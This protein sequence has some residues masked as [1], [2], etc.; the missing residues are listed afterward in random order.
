MLTITKFDRDV[1]REI[2]QEAVAELQALAAKLGL[3]VETAGGK[4]S[5]AE[6]TCH[7]KFTVN[8]AAAREA[9]ERKL[10]N[11]NCSFLELRPS[12]YGAQFTSRGVTYAAFGFTTSGKF[13]VKA[14][15]VATGKEMRF[16]EVVTQLIIAKRP[17]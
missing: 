16:S 14:R 10:W 11:I 15:D 4:F 13:P 12:D 9:G 2:S 3:K 1:C 6:Y 7:I 5:D 8:D 17:K